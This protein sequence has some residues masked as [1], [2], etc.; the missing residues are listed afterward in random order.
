MNWVEI[1]GY[2]ASILIVISITMESIVKLRIVNFIRAALLG[3]YGVFIKFVPIILV[4]YFIVV[5]I[6]INYGSFLKT[7]KLIKTVK[8]I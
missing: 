5:T 4:N 3:T 2:I 6:S 8:G 7:E 1:L